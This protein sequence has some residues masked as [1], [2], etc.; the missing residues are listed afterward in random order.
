MDS[1][2]DTGNRLLPVKTWARS[3]SPASNTGL[4]NYTYK[5]PLSFYF[6]QFFINILI[7]P[8]I[9]H[10][11][12]K[13]HY[14]I[15]VT[16]ATLS[17]FG[18]LSLMDLGLQ[19]AVTKILADAFASAQDNHEQTNE[20]IQ[21]ALSFYIICGVLSGAAVLVFSFQPQILSKQTAL[22]SS[23]SSALIVVAIFNLLIFP[24]LTFEATAEALQEYKFIRSSSI[25]IV[26][27]WGISIFLIVQLHAN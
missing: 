3:S 13:E 18:W 24:L 5:S 20:F 10:S 11:V 15:I 16:T 22:S 1:I 4:K 6:F 25:I 9:I 27:L 8:L 19:G 2:A 26:G 21:T 23:I 14:G 17:I 7:T 12:G